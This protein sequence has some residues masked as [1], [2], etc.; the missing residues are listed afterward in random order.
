MYKSKVSNLTKLWLSLLALL[1]LLVEGCAILSKRPGDIVIQI[2]E[3]RL[4]DYERL[5]FKVKWLGLPV[6]TI[7][8]SIKGIEKINERDAYV[9]EVLVKT[10]IFCSAIYKIDDRFVSYMD[11]VN[12]YTLRHEVYRREGRYKKDAVT[13]FDQINHK[14]YFKNFID[15]SEK[16]FDIPPGVQDTLSASY[17]FMLLPVRVGEKIEY[18]VCNNEDNY[19][20][21]GVIQSTTFINLSKLGRKEAFLMQPYARLNG[22]NVRKGKIRG[23]FGCDKRRLPL[24]IIIKAPVFTKVTAMLCKIEYDKN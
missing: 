9:L 2:P 22:D 21:F 20:L 18:T 12:L 23:Y 13:D 4:P 8:A 14:A 24:F 16:V 5:T 11:V 17:Y 3:S 7:I 15:K 10:N 6:G 19:Q 1:L